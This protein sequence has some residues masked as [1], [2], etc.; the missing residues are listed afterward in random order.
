MKTNKGL[1]K[2]KDSD[3]EDLKDLIITTQTLVLRKVE[4]RSDVRR[5]F[6]ITDIF[7]YFSV[8]TPKS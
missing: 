8:F 6:P 4:K 5:S 1:K 3:P 2:E 7:Q